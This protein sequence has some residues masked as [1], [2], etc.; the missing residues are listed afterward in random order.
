MGFG[1]ATATTTAT[2]I[3]SHRGQVLMRYLGGGVENLACG[4]VSSLL[5]QVM[6]HHAVMNKCKTT[7]KASATKLVLSSHLFA[8]GSGHITI[9]IMKILIVM[10]IIIITHIYIEH[11]VIRLS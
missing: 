3:T 9:I 2:S 8:M 11:T 1:T 5:H 10:M 6:H 7:S 4:V